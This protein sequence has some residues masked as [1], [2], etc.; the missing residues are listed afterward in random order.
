MQK[1]KG[2]SLIVLVITIIVMI[3]L[4][5][6]VVITL[7]N[8]GIIDKAGQAVSATDLK[9]VQDLATMIWLDV[10]MEGNKTDDELR[11]EVIAGLINQNVDVSKYDI[12]VTENGIGVA[13]A[14]GTLLKFGVPYKT[15]ISEDGMT[16]E[17]EFVFYA[18]G[19]ASIWGKYLEGEMAG[20]GFAEYTP[21][22]T[23]IYTKTQVDLGDDSGIFNIS[24]DG[25][26]LTDSE[27]EFTLNNITPGKLQKGV[28]YM[29]S[30]P[31]Y[32][33]YAIFENDGSM[34]L[35]INGEVEET[36]PASEITYAD[37]YIAIE[38]MI[39]PI[40]PTGKKIPLLES[41]VFEVEEG[42]QFGKKYTFISDEI[43]VSVA[44]YQDGSVDLWSNGA[45]ATKLEAGTCTYIGNMITDGEVTS[46]VSTDGTY[47][48]YAGNP[49]IKF[50]LEQPS[51][52]KYGQPYIYAAGSI[53]YAYVFYENGASDIYV[54]NSLAVSNPAGTVTYFNDKVQFVEDPLLGNIVCDI[55]TDGTIITANTGEESIQFVLG[56][57][58]CKHE[59]IQIVDTEEHMDMAI[60]QECDYS[61]LVIPQGATYYVS[62]SSTT[63]GDYSGATKIYTAGQKYPETVNF[64]D[65]YVYQ[66]Y[67]YRYT[68]FYNTSSWYSATSSGWGVRCINNTEMPGLI[69]EEINGQPIRHMNY[70][71]A[72]LN[73]LKKAPD[74]P[75]TVISLSNTFKGCSS[76]ETGTIIPDG[77]TD[78]SS[79]FF[80]CISLSVAPN[81]PN[82]VTSLMYTFRG[83][84]SLVK[85]PSI[86]EGVTTM[87]DTF[88]ECTSLVEAPIIP[89][90]VTNMTLTFYMC[91]S[92]KGTVEINASNLTA[93]TSCFA[94]VDM[95]NITLTGNTTIE[96]LNLVG[97]TGNNWS[98]IQ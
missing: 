86:G 79:T 2:I 47:F 37:N 58:P 40:Y 88:R 3:I 67:E 54:N 8:T 15:T 23:C 11:N 12:T 41:I 55:N 34:K 75:K 69:L 22:G 94:G 62:V 6:S 51:Q 82:S 14:T 50:E 70:T 57:F 20:I 56:K 43:A 24:S 81:I 26:K 10:S 27:I 30:Y 13:L 74:I 28:A 73:K 80:D 85:A 16:M 49:E 5:A 95:R 35:Y 64:K 92:L 32:P 17:I 93:Y 19:S 63:L 96:Q 44:F 71:F 33:A 89:K 9:N 53:E 7:S 72:G 76:L 83:C 65:V 77:V 42:I 87:F 91:T 1:K 84:T 90:N 21:A 52:I 78:M 66:N 31:E 4:A 59:N 36:I 97:A 18:D 68:Q 61:Y 39:I 98:N 29:C 46:I 25:T 60:C 48:L 38:D 45:Y